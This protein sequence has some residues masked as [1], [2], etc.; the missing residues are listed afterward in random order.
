MTD[1]TDRGQYFD[2][3]LETAQAV[4][5]G[6]ISEDIKEELRKLEE[7]DLVILQFPMYWFSF[8]AILKGWI[9]R[10]FVY[11]HVY[12]GERGYYDDA[13]YKVDVLLI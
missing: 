8:P 11:D 9:D 10:V 12:G 7:A 5:R 2:Y 3:Q 6:T 1:Y 13:R 4:K